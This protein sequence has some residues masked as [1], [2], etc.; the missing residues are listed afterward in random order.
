M[1]ISNNYLKKNIVIK[2]L[3]EMM[4]AFILLAFISFTGKK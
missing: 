1:S 4:N 3:E 2:I